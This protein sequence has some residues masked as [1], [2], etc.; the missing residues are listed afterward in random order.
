[1]IYIYGGADPWVASGVTWLKGK[2]QIHVYVLPN[3]SHTTRIVS[4][5]NSTQ[6]EIK[7]LLMQ[8]LNEPSN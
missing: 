6:K 8:W 3:G 5:D 4:F 2:Q 7:D 1:M